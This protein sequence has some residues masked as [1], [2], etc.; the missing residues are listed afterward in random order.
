MVYKYYLSSEDS[1]HINYNS[2]TMCQNP[3]YYFGIAHSNCNTLYKW[4]DKMVTTMKKLWKRITLN[5]A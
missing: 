3:D 2:S 4:N 5:D 1:Q